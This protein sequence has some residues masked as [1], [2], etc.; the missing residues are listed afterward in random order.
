M[1]VILTHLL[2]DTHYLNSVSSNEWG[3][4]SSIYTNTVIK[5]S[6]YQEEVVCYTNHQGTFQKITSKR[7]FI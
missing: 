1:N 5:E 2:I 6:E 7:I 3:L 4:D